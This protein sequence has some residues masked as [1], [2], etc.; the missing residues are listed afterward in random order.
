ML[1]AASFV[2]FPWSLPFREHAP[3]TPQ[4]ADPFRRQMQHS[5]SANASR[6]RLV[7]KG[8]VWEG[9][10][11]SRF[12]VC[13]EICDDRRAW[14]SFSSASLRQRGPATA[15]DVTRKRRRILCVA[16]SD[17]KHPDLPSSWDFPAASGTPMIDL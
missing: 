11:N 16:Y 2:T 7:P 15:A 8:P 6:G 14:P 12:P 1:P 5:I 17:T 3:S 4:I 10:R 9:E 13:A